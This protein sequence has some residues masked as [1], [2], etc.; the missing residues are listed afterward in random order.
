MFNM[1]IADADVDAWFRVN[2]I[3]RR[4]LVNVSF[5]S[6]LG[7][8]KQVIDRQS[9]SLLFVDKQLLD[10]S[11]KD[12]IHYV[13]SKYPRIKII[14]INGFSNSS[15]RLKAGADMVISRPIVPETIEQAIINMV[16]PVLP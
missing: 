5:V 4:Y 9:L 8:A 10:N 11:A 7:L 12:F 1:L 14:L 15:R 13:K 6:N 2:A 3:L 16:N